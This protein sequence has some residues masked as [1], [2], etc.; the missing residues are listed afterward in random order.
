MPRG[1]I[2]LGQA[3]IAER[4]EGPELIQ[5][6][7]ADPL[8]ILRHRIVLGNATFTNDARHRLRLRHALLFHQKFESAI[9]PTAGRHLEYAGL[10][11]ICIDDGPNTQALQERSLRNAFG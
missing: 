10:V 8:V 4:L 7:Q 6:M 5:R 9:A 1:N 3:E 2:F 11:A